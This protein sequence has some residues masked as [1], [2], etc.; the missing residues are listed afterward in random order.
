VL[1]R[2]HRVEDQVEAAIREALAHG[3]RRGDVVVLDD[4]DAHVPTVVRVRTVVSAVGSWVL[5]VPE[6]SRRRAVT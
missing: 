6:Q 4:E 2:H 1:G 3:A 5:F